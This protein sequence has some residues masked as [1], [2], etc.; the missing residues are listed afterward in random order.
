MAQVRHIEVDQRANKFP[1]QLKKSNQ[2]C[3]MDRSNGTHRLDF[4]NQ[5]FSTRMSILNPGSIFS[6]SVT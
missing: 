1:A 2:L 3:Q 6:P 4:D 5:V